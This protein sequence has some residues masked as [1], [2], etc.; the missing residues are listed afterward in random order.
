MDRILNLDL[1]ENSDL[2]AIVF[3][4]LGGMTGKAVIC[5]KRHHQLMFYPKNHLE[6]II[7]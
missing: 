5:K 1:V 4:F 3:R 2:A 7:L 6:F